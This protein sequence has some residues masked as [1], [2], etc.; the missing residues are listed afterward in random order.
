MRTSGVDGANLL[1]VV[2]TSRKLP[3]ATGLGSAEEEVGG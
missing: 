2:I 1:L 3:E